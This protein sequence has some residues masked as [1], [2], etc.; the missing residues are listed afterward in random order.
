MI[1]YD[2]I[3]LILQYQVST[4][5]MDLVVV[6]ALFVFMLALLCFC[7]ATVFSVNKDLY[8]RPHLLLRIAMRLKMNV[9]G[10]W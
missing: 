6:F 10:S 1:I 9:D 2:I 8:N 4:T 7:V 3:L 5:V